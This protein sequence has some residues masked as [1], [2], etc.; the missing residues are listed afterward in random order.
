MLEA[1][2]TAYICAGIT[3]MAACA[4]DPTYSRRV[5][6]DATISL[7]NT[8]ASGGR[9]VV[10]LS[11]NTV[12]DGFSVYPHEDAIRQPTTEYGRQKVATEDEILALQALGVVVRIGKVLFP[13][14]PLIAGFSRS[15]RAG[16]PFDAFDD[17]MLSP[18]SLGYLCRS[19][20][21]IGGMSEAGVFH[22]SGSVEWSYA[23]LARAM[24]RRLAVGAEVVRAESSQRT[25]RSILFRPVHPA[26]GM[27]R[28][29]LL[30]GI[31]AESPD[32]VLDAIVGPGGAALP[33]AVGAD[34]GGATGARSQIFPSR[35][36]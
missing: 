29:T 36:P 3:S 15:I 24:A 27:S 34:G 18:I 7:A 9:R 35:N 26:L 23:D 31:G 20:I 30:C 13:E 25:G 1:G 19:L 2:G 32:T 16:E 28:T 12:F 5:N 4:N 11:S 33:A 22:L 6:V 10:F 14:M 8:L 21:Q 17:L